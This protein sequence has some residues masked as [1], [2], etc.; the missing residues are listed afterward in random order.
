M[1]SYKRV[2]RRKSAPTLCGRRHFPARLENARLSPFAREVGGEGWGNFIA[3]FSPYRDLRA[4]P[5]SGRLVAKSKSKIIQVEDLELQMQ[6][7]KDQ[8]ASEVTPRL[9]TFLSKSFSENI[10]LP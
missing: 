2:A 3:F 4:G 7:L 8:H 10:F 5:A 9:T 1:S 6:E